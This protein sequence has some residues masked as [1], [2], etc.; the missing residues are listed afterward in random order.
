V[1]DAASV[2]TGVR[3]IFSSR[4]SPRGVYGTDPD[5]AIEAIRHRALRQLTCRNAGDGRRLGLVIEGGGMRGSTTAGGALALAHLGLSGL[6]DDVYATSAGVM[7]AAYYLSRQEEI[8]I[9]IY[10]DDLATRAFYNPWRCWKVLDVDYVM[11]DVV[12]GRKRL[13]IDRLR[14]SPSRFH[15]ALLD[16]STGE[17]LVVDTSLTKESTYAVLHAALSVPVLYN[18]PVMVAGRPCMDGGLAIPFPL[19]HA[20][21]DGCTDILVL[22]SH[23][24]AYVSPEYALWQDILFRT[25]CARG[26]AGTWRTY[27]DRVKASTQY[28]DLATGHTPPPAGVNIATVCTEPPY[29]ASL[30]MDRAALMRSSADFGR[31]TLA[32]LGATWVDWNLGPASATR[33]VT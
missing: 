27:R 13:D 32:A 31:R 24:V 5:R 21:A 15:V 1:S 19:R 16:R 25:M 30:T 12:K 18:R 3:A 33:L 10:F 9:S 8:G 29:V 20:I 6:F 14:Q 17:S 7:N 11:E 2:Q 26:S 28:R 23:P 4:P 22:Q